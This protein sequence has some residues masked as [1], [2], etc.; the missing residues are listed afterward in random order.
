V[1]IGVFDS[2]IGGLNVLSEL[3]GLV[4]DAHY[5][6]L[7]D[8]ANVPYGGRPAEQIRELSQKNFARLKGEGIDL[9]V[10]AC[11]SVSIHALEVI[12]RELGNTPVVGM[13]EPAVSLAT[14]VYEGSRAPGEPDG[15]LLI[16]GTQATIRSGTYGD[17]FRAHFPATR[18]LE[19][20]CP[21]FV[22]FIEL[23]QLR[24]PALDEAVRACLQDIA[25]EPVGLA[26]LACTHYAWIRESI[27]R[28]LPGWVVVDPSRAAALAARTLAWQ[29]RGSQATEGGR[30]SR[31]D[32]IFTA[33]EKVPDFARAAMKAMD[34]KLE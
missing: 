32:W 33:P 21:L 13:V 11:N 1:K 12:Q 27:E 31:I 24:G 9:A 10:V 19:Q 34:S 16:L 29:I 26:L 2:G 14:Q 7:G 5:V 4:P 20:A 22:P 15:P 17:R 3:V 18:V 30:P 25:L 6:Y 8:S 23:G 28:A